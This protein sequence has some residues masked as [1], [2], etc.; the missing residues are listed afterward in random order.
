MLEKRYF[1]RISALLL[2]LVLLG[3]VLYG[4]E[5]VTEFMDTVLD[6]VFSS[7]VPSSFIPPD[8]A[9]PEATATIAPLFIPTP[10]PTPVPTPTPTPT[11]RIDEYMGQTERDNLLMDYDSIF[12]ASP[13]HHHLDL[14]TEPSRD[15]EILALRN[16]TT[17]N[18]P[19]VVV[20]DTVKGADGTEFYLVQAAFSSEKG[21]FEKEL[22]GECKYNEDGVTGTYAI[23]QRPGCAVFYTT[24]VEERVNAQED[25]NAVR[26]LGKMKD[27]WYVVTQDGHFG[28]IDPAQ[29]RTVSREE[30][31]DYLAFGI[32][33]DASE[34]FSLESF[35]S[36]LEA[37]EGQ[38]AVTIEDLIY[39]RLTA[40]GLYLLPGY[41]R[42]LEK[43]LGNTEL[44]PDELYQDPVYNSLLFKLWNSAGNFVRY[45]EHE[46][47][48]SYIDKYTDVERGDLIFMSSY[49]SNVKNIIPNVEVVARG[50]YS[51]YITGCYVYLGDDRVLT[52]NGGVVRIVDNFSKGSDFRYFDSARRI[53]TEV[54]DYKSHFLEKVISAI[55]DRLG[56]PYNNFTRTGDRSYDCSGIVCWALRTLG[57]HRTKG[58]GK[59]LMPETTAS[60]LATTK[61]LYT[62]DGI[63]FTL[64]YL[65]PYP[66]VT[67]D[68]SRL[69]RGDFVFLN[70]SQHAKVSHIMIYLGNNTCIHSTT[71][72]SKY[73]G[74]LVSQIRPELKKLYAV[75][76][77]IID[78]K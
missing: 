23:M 59:V 52:V 63:T 67:D 34:T 60:G 78:M 70:G 13:P 15:A 28:Y 7:P 27:F 55:Y 57:V 17:A 40:E 75:T 49:G 22:A 51:G 8:T 37:M 5:P 77:H 31:E 14:L 33:Q 58:S 11:P 29:L 9:L 19:Y 39:D 50:K 6:S 68:L 43:P 54:T 2:F 16:R 72:D 35:V 53:S 3:T 73:R 48:W 46:T 32:V 4:C 76:N 30:M 25:Y 21:Y 41:Y 20:L 56:T 66:R 45:Q 18:F 71:I 42:F 69:E 61:L 74:T 10:V 47:Q 64:D 65:N 1:L 24:N 36:S 12:L 44:Y 26:V 38:E 62:G